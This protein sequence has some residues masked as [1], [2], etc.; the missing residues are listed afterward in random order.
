MFFSGAAISLIILS[1]LEKITLNI[2]VRCLGL[3]LT[4]I[5]FFY[6]FEVPS[7]LSNVQSSHKLIIFLPFFVAYIIRF[8][9]G[10]QRQTFS[11]EDIILMSTFL[12]SHFHLAEL[13]FGYLFVKRSKYVL[14]LVSLVLWIISFSQHSLDIYDGNLI[15][16]YSVLA[17]MVFFILHSSKK[18]PSF[19]F[20]I[21]SQ[22]LLP[23]LDWPNFPKLI[24]AGL[25]FIGAKDLYFY[26]KFNMKTAMSALLGLALAQVLPIASLIGIFIVLMLEIQKGVPLE[27]RIELE[28]SLNHFKSLTFT[29]LSLNLFLIVTRLENTILQLSLVLGLFL[30]ISEMNRSSGDNNRSIELLL[31]STALMIFLGVNIV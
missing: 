4:I 16:I 11:K 23:F 15:R 7:F 28:K 19:S 31:G 24:L 3:F 21:W 10:H 27:E 18:M 12:F 2:A 30:L 14:G 17:L 26:G 13:V 29:M 9:K 25:F 8:L 22:F 20:L 1:F 6:L 5:T